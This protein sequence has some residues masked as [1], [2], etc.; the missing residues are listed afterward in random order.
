MSNCQKA[1]TGYP[2]REAYPCFYEQVAYGLATKGFALDVD[3]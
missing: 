2:D 1:G 3:F